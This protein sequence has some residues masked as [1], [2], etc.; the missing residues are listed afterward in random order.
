LIYKYHFKSLVFFID[1]WNV[2]SLVRSLS[3]RHRTKERNEQRV[4]MPQLSKEA[5]L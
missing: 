5:I 2:L 1:V 4:T 3:F